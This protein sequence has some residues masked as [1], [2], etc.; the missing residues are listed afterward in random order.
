MSALYAVF[1]TIQLIYLFAD[2]LFTLP[3]EFTFAEYA[4]SGFFE[5]LAVTIINISLMLI[6]NTIF[7]DNKLLRFL[8][9]FMT[10]CTYIMIASATYRMLLYISAYHLTFLRIFVLLVLFIDVFILAGIMISQYKKEFP[11]FRYCVIVISFCYI[12]FSFT[13]PDYFIASYLEQHKNVLSMDDMVYL[14]NDLSLDAAPIVIPLINIQERWINR[15]HY[16]VN[17]IMSY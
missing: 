5:L 16:I 17:M 10:S 2:G 14:V 12:A 4:R 15:V 8:I 6:C 9:C 1:C 7:K 11:L 3:T 13:K